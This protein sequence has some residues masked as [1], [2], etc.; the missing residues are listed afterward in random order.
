ME[1]P[2][3]LCARDVSR[4]QWTSHPPLK[5]LV[6]QRAALLQSLCGSHTASQAVHVFITVHCRGWVRLNHRAARR[7]RNGAANSP[8]EPWPPGLAL[9]AGPHSVLKKTRYIF[10]ASDST[11]GCLVEGMDSPVSG[12]NL[13]AIWDFQ[14]HGLWSQRLARGREKH[15]SLSVVSIGNNH[16]LTQL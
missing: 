3:P 9:F 14:T 11:R 13:W 12:G 2:C 15:T 8:C 6:E 5:C 4:N 16:W 7:G 1:I 10:I